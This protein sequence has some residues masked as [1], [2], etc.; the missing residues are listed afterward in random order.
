MVAATLETLLRIADWRSSA[1]HDGAVEGLVQRF[2][3][4]G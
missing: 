3:E 1:R 2:P 4:K